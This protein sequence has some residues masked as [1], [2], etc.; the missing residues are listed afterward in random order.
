MGIVADAYGRP[1]L[2][3]ATKNGGLLILDISR[4]TKPR[5]IAKIG[6]ESL[7]SLHVMN[8]F[9]RGK[10]VYLALGD[11]F[12]ARAGAPAGLA[13]VDVESP[14]QPKVVAVWKSEEIL[15]GSTV[16]VVDGNYAY[17]GAMNRGVMIFDVSRPDKVKHICTYQPEIRF[18]LKVPQKIR[19]PNVRGLTAPGDFLYVAYDA[20]G[21]R[22]LDV[23]DPKHPKEI[24]RYVNKAMGRKPHAYNSVVVDNNLAYIAS[25]YAGLEIVDVTNPSTIRPVG[26]WNPWKA[27]TLRNIWF[28]SAGHTNQVFFDA[29]K[30]LVFL[31]AGASELQVVDVAIPARP[32]LNASYQTP[33]AKLAVWGIGGSKDRIYLAYIK[34]IIP[35]RGTWSG[36]KAVER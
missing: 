14:K 28:N 5:I 24:G 8:L 23:A 30:R 35:F 17:L 9:Q 4:Q 11:F 6:L 10:Y 20:G 19:Y 29:N 36:I 34:S 18:P 13:V 12:D 27:H 25:D 15:R 21:L 7:A 33:N 22:I 3:V 26:W 2:H 31:S 16:V 1:Y 32:R